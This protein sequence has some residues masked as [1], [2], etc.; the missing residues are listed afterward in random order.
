L[1]IPDL[2]ILSEFAFEN[3][4]RARSTNV[5][6]HQ[7]ICLDPDIIACGYLGFASGSGQDF[8]S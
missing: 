7:Y 4:D 8:F 3:P 1:P 6:G 2:G 5:M